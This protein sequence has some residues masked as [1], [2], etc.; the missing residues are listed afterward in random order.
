MVSSLID[1]DTRHWKA[2]IIR[3][4]FLPL[5]AKTI[6]NI[7]LSF[8]LPDDSIVWVGN[9]CGVFSMKSA[10]YV[11]LPLVDKFIEVKSST[12]DYRTPLWKKM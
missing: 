10:Y 9:K 11:A 7:L 12:G 8:N 6:L 5:E 1:E 3:S 2:D 4:L